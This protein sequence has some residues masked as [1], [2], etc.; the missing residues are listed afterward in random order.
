MQSLSGFAPSSFLVMTSR[1]NA[2]QEDRDQR[3]VCMRSDKL[4]QPMKGDVSGDGY[5]GA[6]S[7]FE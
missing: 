7:T 5:A 4:D 2:Q 3:N 6:S 1:D